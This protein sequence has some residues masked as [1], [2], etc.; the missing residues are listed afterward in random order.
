MP[1]VGSPVSVTLTAVQAADMSLV[2]QTAAQTDKAAAPAV[3]KP[4]AAAVPKPELQ[5]A[6]ERTNA[7]RQRHQVGVARMHV[8]ATLMHVSL[9]IWQQCH[10]CLLAVNVCRN[11]SI[12]TLEHEL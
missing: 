11:C 7:Y 10:S 8:T 5:A 1:T 3:L 4:L 9:C 6:L 12:N 2:S